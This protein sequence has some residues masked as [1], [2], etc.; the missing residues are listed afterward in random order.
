VWHGYLP[1]FIAFL[2]AGLDLPC[3]RP[4]RF[5]PQLYLFRPQLSL[6]RPRFDLF[7]LPLHTSMERADLPADLKPAPDPRLVCV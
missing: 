6:F 2:L 7:R 3:L 1:I 4:S 5:R